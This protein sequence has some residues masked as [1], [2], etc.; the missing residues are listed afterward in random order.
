LYGSTVES[1]IARDF[2][3]VQVWP[4]AYDS[5]INKTSLAY[6][7]YRIIGGSAPSVYLSRLRAGDAETPPISAKILERYLASH[8]ND[9]AFLWADNFHGFM[10]NRQARLLRLIEQATGQWAYRRTALDDEIETDA[11]TAEAEATIATS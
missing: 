8:L 4:A 5:I 2:L 10:A 3:K 6:R 9:P 1:R 11:E 7:T